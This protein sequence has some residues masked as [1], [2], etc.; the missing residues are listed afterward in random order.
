MY[1][2]LLFI[3]LLWAWGLDSEL[4]A[5]KAGVLLLESHLQSIFFL[6]ILEMGL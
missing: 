5:Y 6:A 3:Y 4:H 2:S 1:L